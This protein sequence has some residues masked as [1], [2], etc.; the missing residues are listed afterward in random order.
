MDGPAGELM[1]VHRAPYPLRTAYII[2][3]IF[4]TTYRSGLLYNISLGL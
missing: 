4:V 3:I 2:A 1:I